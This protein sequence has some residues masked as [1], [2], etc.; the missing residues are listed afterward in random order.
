MGF[1]MT[2][3]R[4]QQPREEHT[5]GIAVAAGVLTL[6]V[7]VFSAAPL[8]QELTLTPRWLAV[9]GS[10]EPAA[11]E[12]A[13]LSFELGGRYGFFGEDGRFVF[14]AARAQRYLSLSENYGAEYEAAPDR[15]RVF[16]P[17]GETAM[18]IENPG[19][20]PFFM[21]GSVFI[22]GSGQDALT[23]LD[24]GGKALWTYAFSAPLTCA[25]AAAGFVLAGGL[26]GAVELI[27]PDGKPAVLPFA[28]GGSRLPV[29][30]GCALSQ[31]GSRAAIVS[32]ID[33]QRFLFL[34]R[35]GNTLNVAYHEFLSG[36]FRRP[37]RVVFTENGGRVVY[38]REGGV[39]LFDAS[40]G[41]SAFIPLEG[42]IIALDEDGS[43][44]AVFVLLA[45]EGN[46]KTLAVVRGPDDEVIRSRFHSEDAFL[47]RRLSRV[48]VGGGSAI[49][50]F[51]MGRR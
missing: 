42:D 13:A 44:G 43:E 6:A 20:Y 11:A 14:T 51:E 25:A 16:N 10:G 5:R 32:G 9:V 21:D 4:E 2:M 3:W 34:A 33:K 31:D 24:G 41:V 7:L 46:E 23:R 17:A 39:G 19:G 26:D 40:S 15:L 48:Y 22:I 30:L 45:G 12:G 37:V 36:G 35:S 47:G 1:G 49:V 38:E 50:S 28:P 29:I 8:P 27:G 18:E